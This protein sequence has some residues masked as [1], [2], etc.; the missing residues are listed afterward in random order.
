MGAPIRTS[1][2]ARDL[3][4]ALAHEWQPDRLLMF[5]YT[6]Y[7]D[8]SGTHEGSETTVMGGML[9][10]A[11]HW[12]GFEE[13]FE[14]IQ[15]KHRFRIFHT[16]KFKRRVG[17]FK[18]WT[19]EQ[20]LAL[21]RDLSVLTGFGRGEGVTVS[22]N[23]ALYRD[24]Y[25]KPSVPVRGHFDSRYGLCFRQCLGHLIS[26]TVKRKYRKKIPRLDVILE[27]GH[28]NAG[29]AQRI[30]LELKRQFAAHD[31]DIL[32]HIAFVDKDECGQLMM[33]DFLAHKAMLDDRQVLEGR[34]VRKSEDV[35][36]GYTS[37]LSYEYN[38]SVLAH[39]R[40]KA[41]R[42]PRTASSDSLEQPS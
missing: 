10:R 21:I 25:R 5:G 4:F 13:I 24:V 41:L 40:Q 31:L 23:N 15:K 20:C 14:A 35:P 28:E 27:A 2:F 37:V 9:A 30:F 26:E 34:R 38:A 6:A 19:N 39:L 11:D 3:C 32:R 18:G 16:K 33:A 8:E 36:K 29:D 42:G 12:K 7:L 1:G 22:L 17:D